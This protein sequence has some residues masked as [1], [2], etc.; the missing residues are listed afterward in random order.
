MSAGRG[1]SGGAVGKWPD[2]ATV[3]SLAPA[4]YLSIAVDTRYSFTAEVALAELNYHG[5][6]ILGRQEEETSWHFLS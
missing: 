5:S 6:F 1:D 2:E 3:K 4:G